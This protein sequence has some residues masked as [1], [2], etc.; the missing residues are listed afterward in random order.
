M[1]KAVILFQNVRKDARGLTL[2]RADRYR[3]AFGT[4][5]QHRGPKKTG[6]LP[7]Q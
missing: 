3:K 6:S 5:D 2:R 4:E 7:L 1:K